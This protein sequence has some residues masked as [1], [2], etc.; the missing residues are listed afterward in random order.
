MV[1]GKHLAQEVCLSSS[2]RVFNEGGLGIDVNLMLFDVFQSDL[3]SLRHVNVICQSALPCSL[4][5]SSWSRLGIP[6]QS[7]QLVNILLTTSA[8]VS[9]VKVTCAFLLLCCP[10]PA[11]C[12]AVPASAPPSYSHVLPGGLTDLPSLL[13]ILH[14]V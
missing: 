4:R 9:A 2:R 10:W 12:S 5:V 7:I 1:S 3:F 13:A 14:L 6:T 11:L 8:S